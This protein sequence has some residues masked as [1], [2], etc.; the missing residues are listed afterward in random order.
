ML[1]SAAACC[2]KLLSVA[3]CSCMLVYAVV[4]CYMLLYVAVC[5]CMLLYDVGSR[6]MSL[7]VFGRHCFGYEV[8]NSKS[9][10]AGGP[11]TWTNYQR[12]HNTTNTC[13]TLLFLFSCSVSL[14]LVRRRFSS[15]NMF[16]KL[17]TQNANNA[18]RHRR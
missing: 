3:V 14:L 10:V 4:F 6:C 11:R 2:C 13:F 7:F 5:C 9:E 16:G 17:F 15:L 12:K 18:C 1:P 8:F